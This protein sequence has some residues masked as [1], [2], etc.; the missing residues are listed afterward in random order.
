M[1]TASNRQ[2][3]NVML[4]IMIMTYF[5][6]K[7]DINTSKSF[8]S[9]QSRL[10]KSAIAVQAKHLNVAGRTILTRKFLEKNKVNNKPFTLHLYSVISNM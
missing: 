6:N 7:H 8:A 2:P 10:A 4:N 3:E 1:T 5:M 9:Q